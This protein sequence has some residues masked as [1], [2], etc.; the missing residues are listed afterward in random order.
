MRIEIEFFFLGERREHSTQR[1]AM[2]RA[3]V[4]AALATAAAAAA[5][6][7]CQSYPPGCARGSYR[8][9]PVLWSAPCDPVPGHTCTAECRSGYSPEQGPRNATYVCTP[10]EHEWYLIGGGDSR[11]QL[12]CDRGARE[13]T[14]RPAWRV[15]GRWL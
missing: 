1:G 4:T 9:C 7:E 14:N 6:N 12:I 10:G 15:C 11:T 3:L 13:P 5:G 8:I 2:L